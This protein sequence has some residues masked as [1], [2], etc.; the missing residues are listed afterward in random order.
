MY[1]QSSKIELQYLEYFELVAIS[2]ST[3]CDNTVS[4]CKYYCLVHVC[5]NSTYVKSFSCRYCDYGWFYK[6]SR[7]VVLLPIISSLLP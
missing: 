6:S 1:V 2:Q 3:K 7:N 4:F 5:M